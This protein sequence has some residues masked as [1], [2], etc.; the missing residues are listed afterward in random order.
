MSETLASS[1]YLCIFS[2]RSSNAPVQLGQSQ[3]LQLRADL[4]KIDREAYLCII[5]KNMNIALNDKIQKTQVQTKNYL[6]ITWHSEQSRPV[7][8]PS[9][10]KH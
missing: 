4:L 9:T 8:P 7:T 1:R 2:V 3:L 5:M 10:Q 6:Q